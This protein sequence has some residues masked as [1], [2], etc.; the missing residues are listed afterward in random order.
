M[1]AVSALGLHR[2]LSAVK[3]S[4]GARSG[5]WGAGIRLTIGNATAYR[6][7]VETD[8]CQ[9]T[10]WKQAIQEP[11]EIEYRDISLKSLGI[12]ALLR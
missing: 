8:S 12:I 4:L 1:G 2:W 3:A 9:A 7:R 11:R 5:G 6:T 10:S